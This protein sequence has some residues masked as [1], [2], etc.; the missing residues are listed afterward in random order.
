MASYASVAASGRDP[1]P[2]D[3]IRLLVAH[4]MG[5]A[6]VE[7]VITRIGKVS[8]ITPHGISLHPRGFL[9]AFSSEQDRTKVLTTTSGSLKVDSAMLTFSNP[10]ILP[11]AKERG[12]RFRISRVPFWASQAQLT[13]L[14]TNSGVKVTTLKLETVKGHPSVRTPFA[15]F[16]TS[17]DSP[18]P[19]SHFRWMEPG[20]SFSTR[21][22]PRR[23]PSLPIARPHLL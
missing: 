15:T 13:S 7:H 5:V 3:D 10:D 8:G 2:K 22:P 21:S 16:W 20:C 6:S 23:P 9:L 4:L 17:T 1:P 12:K 11:P 19:Q 14:L 18:P